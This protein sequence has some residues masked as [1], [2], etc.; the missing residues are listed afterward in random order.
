VPEAFLPSLLHR[1]VDDHPGKGTGAISTRNVGLS[2]YRDMVISHVT[3]L[4]N[5]TTFF[6]SRYYV[7]SALIGN[8]P[9]SKPHL[10]PNVAISVV[11]HGLDLPSGVAVS[12]GLLV[13]LQQQIQEAIAIFEPRLRDVR[14]R[15]V[16]MEEKTVAASE[17][18]QDLHPTRYSFY[19]DAE[20]IAE[21]FPDSIRL[22]TELDLVT[23]RCSMA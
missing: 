19:I 7:E 13:Q 4:L 10:Y 15:L 17:G 8:D 23:G 18:I 6:R 9:R 11:N 5:E 16:A 1:L 20:L 12:E 22:K 2:G 21:P 3:K 14:I